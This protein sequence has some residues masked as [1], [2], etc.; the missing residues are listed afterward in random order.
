M[1]RLLAVRNH[2]LVL[3]AV[4]LAAG[5][6]PAAADIPIPTYPVPDFSTTLGTVTQN[7]VSAQDRMADDARSRARAS[8]SEPAAAG[9]TLTTGK[10][11]TAKRMAAAYPKAQ[12]ASV[13]K[14]F[15][16]LLATFATLEDQLAIPHGDL[17]GATA[18]FVVANL[19]AYTDR[20][21]D[22]SAYGPL[23]S[24]LRDTLAANPALGKL[25]AKQRRQ[26]FEELVIV[27]M[28]VAAARAEL[29]AKPDAAAS[30]RLEA[31]AADY[32]RASLGVAADRVQVTSAGLSIAPAP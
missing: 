23:V 21:V 12:R 5:A 25:T 3:A 29:A 8:A 19:E 1:A 18:L 16:Q 24:Q 4:L 10:A 27:G 2:H 15:D 26:L 31:A 32:L 11:G 14:T 22:P 30:S 6:R 9:S 7:I 28:F 20:T 17:A 13:Q